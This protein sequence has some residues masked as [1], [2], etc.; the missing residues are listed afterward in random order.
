L[1][2]RSELRLGEPAAAE[3]PERLLVGFFKS[4]RFANKVKWVK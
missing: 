1:K 2:P 4:P 3:N